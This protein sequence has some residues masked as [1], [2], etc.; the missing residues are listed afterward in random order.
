MKKLLLLL[1]IL[2]AAVPASAQQAPPVELVWPNGAP[3]AVGT[4]PEDK[5]TLTIFLPEASKAVGTGIV[6]CP[7]G[8]Y[9]HLAF[10]HEGV[11]VAEWLNSL[12]VAAFVLKYRLGPRYHYPAQ[13]EDV[14][15]AFRIVR[16]RAKEFGI[17]L[18]RIGI[19]GFSAGGHLAS[20]LG[21]HFEAGDP[22]ATDPLDRMSS[23]PDF[24]ILGYPV[25]TML[26]PYAH[27]GSRHYLLGHNP[28]PELVKK[29]SNELQVTPQSPPTFLFLTDDDNVVPSENSVMFY[30]ALHK[31]H[32]PAEIHIFQHGPHGFGLATANSQL[33]IWPT[34]LENWLRLRGLL[35]KWAALSKPPASRA[36]AR[37]W[38]SG[39]EIRIS[40][41]VEL[42]WVVRLE[43]GSRPATNRW[44][45]CLRR[46]KAP[47]SGRA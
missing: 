7:G 34:L 29:L 30:E 37:T 5:P 23:R 16:S 15:R 27:E 33:S 20:T 41:S 12:G 9:V 1:A 8:G 10:D 25:I 28:D 40:G 17:S 3:G 11:K 18:D 21:T 39:L 38:D 32:V 22:N 42:R 46:K 6:V 35:T 26:Q 24:M 47:S 4:L 43:G 2:A 14:Q 19:M 36:E 44:G 45:D 31:A 13:F